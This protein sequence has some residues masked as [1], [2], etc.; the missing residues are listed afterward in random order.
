MKQILTIGLALM[1][2]A[3]F[4]VP[5]FAVDTEVDID[6]SG[7]APEVKCAWVAEDTCDDCQ[8][9]CGTDCK[10]FGSQIATIPGTYTCDAILI[11]PFL[12]LSVSRLPTMPS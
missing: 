7:T 6:T 9:S 1:L 4:T 12:T 3:A 5:A 2:V 11:N 8:T 10:A